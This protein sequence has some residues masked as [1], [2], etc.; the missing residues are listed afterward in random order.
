MHEYGIASALLDRIVAEARA[1]GAHR[2]L[3]AR[4]RLGALSGVDAGLLRTA[5]E[6]CRA[7]TR[8]AETTLEVEAVAV[9]WTCSRC[10]GEI[11]VGDVLRCRGCGTGARL[12]TGDE[13]VLSGIEVEVAHV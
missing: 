1:R 10:G 6:L 3:V 9:Q 2:I 5:W 4:V 11:P 12:A 7:G 8:C 13:I